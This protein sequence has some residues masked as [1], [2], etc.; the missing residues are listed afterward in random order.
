MDFNKAKKYCINLPKRTDRLDKVM[1]MFKRHDIDVEIWKAIDGKNHKIPK[2]SPKI[3]QYNKHGILG[4]MMSHRS[5]IA[6]AKKNNYEYIVVFEDDIILSDNFLDEVKKLEYIYFD[7]FYLGGHF[8]SYD[9]DIKRITGQLHECIKV[10]GTY[11]Y[12][13]KNTVYDFILDNMDY[14][15][16]SDEFYGQ[17]VQKKYKCLAIIPFLVNHDV[18]YSD[19]ALT[20]A[21]YKTDNIFNRCAIKYITFNSLEKYGRLGNQLFE[22]ASVIGLANKYNATPIFPTKWTYRDYFNIPDKYFDDIKYESQVTETVFHYIPNLLHGMKDEIIDIKGTLQSEKYFIEIKDTIKKYLTPKGKDVFDKWS[23]G[24]HIRRGDYVNNPN[25]INYGP[26]YYYSVIEKYFNDERY[27]FYVCSE[28]YGY[29]KEH[30]NDDRFIVQKRNEIEDFIILSSCQKLII[31]NSTFSWWA[32]YLSEAKQVIRPPKIFDGN[33]AKTHSE[34]DY[35][36]DNWIVHDDKIN[37]NDVTFIIPVGYDHPDRKENMDITISWIKKC[38]DTTVIVGEQGGEYFKDYGDVYYNFPMEIFHRTRMLNRMTMLSKTKYVINWDADVLTTVKSIIDMVDMLRNGHDFV[39]PY[40]GR[41]IRVGN[42]TYGRDKSMVL[43]LKNGDVGN[44][45]GYDFV[46]IE[47]D[48]EGSV[49]GAIGYNKES[50]INAGMENERFIAYS[51]EDVE[52]YY[53]FKKLEFKIGKSKGALYHINHWCGDNSSVRN[54]YFN[55]GV[56]ELKRIKEM[57]IPIIEADTKKVVLVTYSDENY[58]EYQQRLVSY[59]KISGL[60]DD[61][62]SYDREWLE[63]TDFYLKNME[64]L[65]EKRGG[66]YW[67]WKP[68]IILET[69]DKLEEGSIILYMD[70]GDLFDGDIRKYLTSIKDDVLLTK[71]A[72]KNKEWTKRDCFIKMGCDSKKYHEAVQLEAGVIVATNTVRGK[73]FIDVWLSFCTDRQIISDDKSKLK[74]EYKCFREHRH[75]QSILTNLK[76]RYNIPSSNDIRKYVTCNVPLAIKSPTIISKGENRANAK[77]VTFVIPV[78]YDCQE[79]KENLELIIYY[80]QKHFD[81]NIIIGECCGN[82]FE[83]LSDNVK[84]INYDI[85]IYYRTKMINGLFKASDTRYV[86]NWDADVLM[87]RKQLEKAINALR[88]GNGIIYPYTNF[89]RIRNEYYG[90]RVILDTDFEFTPLIIEEMKSVGGAI[91]Y[92]KELFIKMGMENENIIGWGYE[93]V[94]RYYRYKILG[95]E[96]MRI[97]GNIYHIEHP[98]VSH[99]HPYVGSNRSESR[100]IQNMDIKSLKEYMAKWKWLKTL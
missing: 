26:E 41:F 76:V 51:P 12:I 71:G 38:F 49:G 10:G 65:N 15:Y 54:K 3:N 61:V 64:L 13:M 81:T 34:K 96:P 57:E 100:K 58:T 2:D 52:R 43:K 88:E 66:G 98:K 67:L 11:A 42:G 55:D 99:V 28:D 37:L 19:I 84:Y 6:H 93:D 1:D 22:I 73:N 75:D 63:G 45:L 68:Y 77:D 25:Y 47:K 74:K 14:R 5:L 36:I 95:H 21:N 94:E 44:V 83:Y 72:Y 8:G 4:C 33:L 17:F 91:G 9:N 31:T 90:I 35:W 48:G 92:D 86:F 78:K 20:N 82:Y 60:F 79:R 7:M 70:S 80:L 56:N 59:A 18:T 29:C 87:E 46:G 24:I 97:D 50:F 39:Y 89:V 69:M 85:Q 53:R 40:D 27:T 23:V 30:F 16:G 32:A 62:F